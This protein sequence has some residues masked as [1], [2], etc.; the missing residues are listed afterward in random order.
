MQTST[1][2]LPVCTGA[3]VRK[4]DEQQKADDRAT[5]ESEAQVTNLD[6]SVIETD[7]HLEDESNLTDMEP[8]DP[9]REEDVPA[10]RGSTDLM[11]ELPLDYPAEERPKSTPGPHPHLSREDL[12]NKQKMDPPVTGADTGCCE[13][14]REPLQASGRLAGMPCGERLWG[15]CGSG[16]GTQGAEEDCA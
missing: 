15:N 3:A 8:D 11:E 9:D 6:E 2:V 12:A 4:A 5:A 7:K 13:R 16:G 14:L 10:S 1:Q